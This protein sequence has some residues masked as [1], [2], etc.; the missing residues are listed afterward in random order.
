[1]AMEHDTLLKHPVQKLCV[2]LAAIVSIGSADT[3]AQK[4]EDTNSAPDQAAVEPSLSRK[5]LMRKPLQVRTR[6]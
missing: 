6:I 1:M 2:L 3:C 5:R 4:P